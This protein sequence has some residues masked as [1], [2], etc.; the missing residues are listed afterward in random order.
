MTRLRI[1]RR[2]G[3]GDGRVVVYDLRRGMELRIS[4][5]VRALRRLRPTRQIAHGYR[6]RRAS[7]ARGDFCGL[8]IGPN[9][10]QGGAPVPNE[11]TKTDRLVAT[12]MSEQT[13]G[14][15]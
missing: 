3:R 7:R 2:K 9:R 14:D 15:G 10:Q 5:R 6:R 8:R 12:V 1:R 4:R 13:G 11:R